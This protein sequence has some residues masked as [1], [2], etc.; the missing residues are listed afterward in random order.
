MK[1]NRKKHF[2]AIAAVILALAGY[3]GLFQ[4]PAQ[5]QIVQ[6]HLSQQRQIKEN[7][8][9]NQKLSQLPKLEEEILKMDKIL[10]NFD[11]KIPQGRSHGVFLEQVADIMTKH[12]LSD[13]LVQPGT[14]TDV[15]G[16]KRIPFDL[17][18]KGSVQ[19]IFAFL[20]S[21]EEFER[22]VRF[23]SLKLTGDAA[24]SGAVTMHAQ[25]MI[26]YRPEKNQ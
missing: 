8:L 2:A 19:Q 16:L 23:E 4:F 7:E 26:H 12:G 15:Q 24:Y 3:I 1:L 13:Q 21:L 25:A 5:R 14:E 18:C 17:Q 11:A 22:C 20:R 6:L 9:N 10:A